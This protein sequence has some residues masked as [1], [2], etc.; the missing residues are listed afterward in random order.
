MFRRRYT[1]LGHLLKRYRVRGDEV[2]DGLGEARLWEN[3]CSRRGYEQEGEKEVCH[4]T[5]M[6]SWS[7][8]MARFHCGISDLVGSW[9][10]G[11]VGLIW[12]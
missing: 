9:S 7:F 3:V 10:V 1:T 6:V 4:C 8:Q 2:Q 11:S 5:C 12:E